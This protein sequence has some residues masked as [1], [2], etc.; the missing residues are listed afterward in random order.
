MFS[1]LFWLYLLEL[2]SFTYPFNK[3][4]NFIMVRDGAML[5]EDIHRCRT[6]TKKNEGL[7]KDAG[8]F[9][10]NQKGRLFVLLWFFFFFYSLETNGGA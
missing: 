4:M 10:S 2:L 3:I 8:F 7:V 6:S 1:H 5:F 9:F